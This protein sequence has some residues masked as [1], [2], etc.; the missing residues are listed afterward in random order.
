MGRREGGIFMGRCVE[1]VAVDRGVIQCYFYWK[2][3]RMG[4]CVGIFN[5][6]EQKREVC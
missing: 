1:E 3:W 4:G 2:W 5:G 6:L